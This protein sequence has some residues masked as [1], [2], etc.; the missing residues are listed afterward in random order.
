MKQQKLAIFGGPPAVTPGSVK[1]WPPIEDIDRKMVLASLEGGEPCYGPNCK[2]LEAEFA[3]WAGLPH[4]LPDQR[5]LRLAALSARPG[6]PAAA[7]A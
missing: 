7:G 5:A 1:P 4:A 2:A 3:Q 6:Q